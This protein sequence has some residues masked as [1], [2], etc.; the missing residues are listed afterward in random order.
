MHKMTQ[1]TTRRNPAKPQSVR[2]VARW[3]GGTPT[4]GRLDDG[5]AILQI[6]AHGKEPA[7]YFVTANKDKN[8]R[9]LGYRLVKIDGLERTATYDVDV[10]TPHWTCDCPDATFTDRP[11]GCKHIGG[12]RAALRAAGLL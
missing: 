10:T 9:L 8:G 3:V 11:G 7:F 2:G 5:D 6:T 1:T 4:Q 12:L